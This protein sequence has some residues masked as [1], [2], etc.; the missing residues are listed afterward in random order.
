LVITEFGGEK[1]SILVCYS[2]EWSTDIVL[3]LGGF[4]KLQLELG[5]GG[6]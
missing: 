6:R 3:E 5:G 1:N 2:L 4:G